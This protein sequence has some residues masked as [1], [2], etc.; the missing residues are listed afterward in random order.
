MHTFRLQGRGSKVAAAEADEAMAKVLR[1]LKAQLVSSKREAE[2][3]QT[4]D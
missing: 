2:V 3:Q 1:L 4:V